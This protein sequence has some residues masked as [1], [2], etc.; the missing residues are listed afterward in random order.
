MAKRARDDAES[1]TE[2]DTEVSVGIAAYRSDAVRPCHP[3]GIFQSRW[4]DF[5]ARELSE[6]GA[7][8]CANERPSSAP[9]S[10]LLSFILVKENRTPADALMQL[11][12]A[13]GIPLGC[14]AVAGSKLTGEQS[15]FSE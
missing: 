13:S 2:G 6:S 14:F 8:V 3:S 9:E 10:D 12:S 5:H 7:P 4:A 1:A 11:S 15:P